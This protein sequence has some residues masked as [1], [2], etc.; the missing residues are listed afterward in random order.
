M[1]GDAY[2]SAEH[3]VTSHLTSACHAYLRC[4]DGILADYYIM[5]YLYE[6]VQLDAA[7]YYGRAHRSTVDTCVCSNFDII[8]Y[9][10]IADL[11][12][13]GIAAV[14]LRCETETVSTYDC[15]GHSEYSG[16]FW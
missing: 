13:L 4:A 1:S 14:F 3:A 9:N 5:A 8:F 12:Y 10:Y 2:L 11:G 6:V 16:V 15:T 7:V